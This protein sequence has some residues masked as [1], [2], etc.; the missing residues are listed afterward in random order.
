MSALP[1]APYLQDLS[2]DD[3]FARLRSRAKSPAAKPTGAAAE[4]GDVNALWEEAYAKGLKDGKATTRAALEARIE[5]LKQE[6]EQRLASERRDWVAEQGERLASRIATGLNELEARI[7]DTAARVLEPFLVEEV[8]GQALAEFRNAVEE[9]VAREQGV[10]F[11]FSG[12][13]D[14]LEAVR[15]SLAHRGIAASFIPNDTCEVRM[16]AG[17]TI[18]ETRLGAWVGAIREA[19]Q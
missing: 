17:Q 1:V 15:E 10:P 3:A 6:A 18:I 9:L 4:D 19:V 11:S 2:P 8:R 14:L 16:T 12:P 7:A 13:E 5:E